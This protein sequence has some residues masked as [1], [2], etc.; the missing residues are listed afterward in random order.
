MH[1][2]TDESIDSNR[3]RKKRNA[4]DRNSIL[5]SRKKQYMLRCVGL[6]RVQ[7]VLSVES[8]DDEDDRPLS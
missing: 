6:G 7:T 5:G 8:H 2:K 4:S 3:A 1:H